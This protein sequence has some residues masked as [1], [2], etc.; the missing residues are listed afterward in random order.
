MDVV[1]EKERK[2]KIIKMKYILVNKKGEKYE[3]F[4]M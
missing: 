3:M 2:W 1:L 4:K